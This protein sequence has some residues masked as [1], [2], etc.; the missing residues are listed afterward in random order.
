MYN[1]DLLQLNE[2]S[3]DLT[4]FVLLVEIVDHQRSFPR[5]SA[6]PRVSKVTIPAVV[7]KDDFFAVKASAF[8]IQNASPDSERL[9]PV[10]VNEEDALVG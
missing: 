1:K 5:K 4:R 3:T 10:A 2:T 7:P 8:R 6:R 9:V